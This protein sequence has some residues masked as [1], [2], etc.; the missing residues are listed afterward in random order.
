MGN[1]RPAVD[2]P[3]LAGWYLSGRLLLDGL[4]SGR[5]PLEAINEAIASARNGLALRNVIT[6]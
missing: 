5:Y 4:I 3:K 2:I 6:F 1:T